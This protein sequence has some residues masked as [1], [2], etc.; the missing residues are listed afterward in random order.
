MDNFTGL[1]TQDEA[2]V[3]VDLLKLGVSGRA[4]PF[5]KE[6][7]SSMLLGKFDTNLHILCTE[8]KVLIITNGSY[9]NEYND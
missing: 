5:A 4:G 8:E 1:F 9:I 2:C 3:L 7:V 6:A